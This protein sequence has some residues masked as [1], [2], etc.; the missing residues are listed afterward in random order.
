MGPIKPNSTTIWQL[1]LAGVL[2]GPVF[3]AS[4]ADKVRRTAS[5]LQYE[6]LTPGTGVAPKAS[7]RVTVHYSGWLENGTMFDS[8]W[9]RGEPMSFG[10]NQVI[11]GWT[12]GVQMMK[13]G[14][15]YRFT[16]PGD[17][18]YGERGSPP[19][20]PPNATLIFV[21]ELQKVN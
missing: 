16:I 8:S 10:L 7:D 9:A 3:A 13:Q 21:V 1:E 19:N 17:L 12:E 20:I 6:V 4:P 2:E 18:A 15:R 14:A 5:G 11:K